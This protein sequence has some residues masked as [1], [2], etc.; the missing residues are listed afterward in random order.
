L[1]P[2]IQGEYP[3]VYINGLPKHFN[4]MK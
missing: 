4:V 3:I 1:L 2:L